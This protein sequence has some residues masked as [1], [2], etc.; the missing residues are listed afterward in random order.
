MAKSDLDNDKPQLAKVSFEDGLKQ[1]EE[2]VTQVEN[3][4][5]PLD[6]AIKSYEYGSSL[7]AHLRGI[8]SAAEQK[9]QVLKR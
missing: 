7:V 9:L 5:M 3:G 4:A 6:Q 2:L 8:L 1:L